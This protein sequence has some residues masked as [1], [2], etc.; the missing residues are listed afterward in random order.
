[1]IAIDF[2]RENSEDSSMST[3]TIPT[4]L[5]DELRQAA[6]RAVSKVRDPEA[7]LRACEHMDRA[8]EETR[9]TLGVQ[10]IGVKIIRELRETE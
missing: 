6:R 8:S 3:D 10:D 2:P 7:M 5:M 4:E 1:M 9:K